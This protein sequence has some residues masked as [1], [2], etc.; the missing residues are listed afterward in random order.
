MTLALEIASDAAAAARRV[1]SLVAERARETVEKDGS[2]SLALSKVP[3]EMLDALAT[4]DLPWSAMS[5]YQVDERIAPA[6]H[7]DRNLTAL[8]AGL[9]PEAEASLRP[10]PVEEAKLDEAA[11][12]YAAELPAHLELVHL[13]LGPDGHTA[14]L[15]PGDAVLDVHDRLV[16]I[17]Q[18]YQGRRRMTLT[19]PA[20]AAAHEIVWLVT[21]ETKRDALARLLAG[22]PTIPA[23]QISNPRQLVVS[24]AAAAP[25]R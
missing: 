8:S 19:Y 17:T 11:V 12:R 13:G 20:L 4:N 23:A 6:G 2:F 25:S 14:S 16:A 22:D 9:P 24:D 1:A 5:I 10:M 21:G 18:E 15:M 3:P 7:A